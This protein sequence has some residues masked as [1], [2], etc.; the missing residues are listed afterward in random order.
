MCSTRKSWERF[1]HVSW[2]TNSASVP[3]TTSAVAVASSSPLRRLVLNGPPRW[4]WRIC[5]AVSTPNCQR[6]SLQPPRRSRAQNALEM[7]ATTPWVRYSRIGMV[8]RFRSSEYP[9]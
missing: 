4:P 5:G 9:K 2:V 1:Q 7:P 6:R 8:E 3:F